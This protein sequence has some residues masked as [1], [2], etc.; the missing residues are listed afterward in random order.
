[1]AWTHPAYEAVA[2]LLGTRTGLSFSTHRQDSVE[3]GIRRAMNRAG[4]ADPHRYH[5]LLGVDA[6]ALD[7]LIVELTVGETYFLR[8][9]GQFEFI[10]REVLPEI[11]GRKGSDQMSRT[12]CQSVPPII[13]AWSA[14]CASGEEAYSLAILFEREG[15]AGQTHILAT[16]I[17]RA[18]LAK[19]S[20]AVYSNWSLRGEGAHIAEGYLAR[21]GDRFVLD[22]RIRRRVTFE[23]L[24]LAL[25]VYPSF[26]TG[27][28]GMDLILCRNV[29]IYFDRETVRNVARRL[30]EALAPGGWLITASS[31]PPLA[32]HAQYETV[33]SDAGVFYRRGTGLPPQVTEPP[34]PREGTLETYP[35]GAVEFSAGPPPQDESATWLLPLPPAVEEPAE[36][37]EEARDP[38]RL[39][40]PTADALAEAR[41]ALDRGDYQRACELA[42]NLAE[43]ARGCAVHVRALA[44]LDS[45]RAESVCADAA[46]RHPL[47]TELHYL[48]AV[49]LLDLG[50]DEEAARAARRVLYLDRSLAVAHFT[51][52]SILQRLGDRAGARRAYRNACD[53]CASRPADELMPLAD[54]EHA[55]RLAEAAGVQL[56]VLDTTAEVLR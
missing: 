33:V 10:R 22:E 11:R 43:D 53:L 1:M 32:E 3:H 4:V 48:H 13:R 38:G 14:G 20:Q 12:D 52:G 6:A 29:L 45:T 23:Y 21:R 28:W 30:H 40:A 51:L 35:T 19:A 2:Q 26:G 17:S 34:P 44:N 49:L 9:P 8:E 18:A 56:A 50:R 27:T 36:K 41:Q 39:P 5:E 31:D 55:G 25:D 24:N 37:V 46:E 7:D 54:G 15:L 16:D 47:S 42:A